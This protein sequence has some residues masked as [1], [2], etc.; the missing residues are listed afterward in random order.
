[1]EFEVGDYVKFTGDSWG[2]VKPG[3]TGTVTGTEE[4]FTGDTLYVVA[5]QGE[6]TESTLRADEIEIF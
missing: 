3:M 4:S 2:D 5:W 1:M 6:R